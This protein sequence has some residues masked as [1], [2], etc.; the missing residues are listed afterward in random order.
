[1][2]M[3]SFLFCFLLIFPFLVSGQKNDK[4]KST[5]TAPDGIEG[6]TVGME[7][8]EGFF[9]FY[10]D[11]KSDKIMLVIDK[12]G[13]EFLYVHSL[14]AGIGSNDIGLDKNQL[15]GTEVVYFERHGPKVLLFE[16][17][18]RYRAVSDNVKEQQAVADAFARGVIWGFKLITE[19]DGKILVD[20]TD[21]LMQDAHNVAERLKSGNQGTWSVDQSRSAFYLD[22]TRNFPENTEFETILTFTGK[23]AGYNLRSVSPADDNFSVRQHHSFIQLPDDEYEP[24]TF[25]PRAG[26]F[27]TSYFDY[28]T[29]ISEP[30]EKKFINRHRLE[31]KNPGAEVSDPVEPIIYYLDPGT[32]EPIRSALIEGASWWNQAFE[33][34]GYRDAFQVK[35]LPD[36]ADPMDVRYNMINWVHRSTRG[37]SYGSSVTDPR[38]G[39]IIK[40]H[41]LLGSLRVRQDFLIAEGLLAPYTNGSEVPP[42]ME[43]M[44]LARLRQLSAHEVGHTLGLAHS[45]ASSGEGRAS[46]MDY[47]HPMIGLN[48][49]RID[50]SNAYD[51]KIGSWD[52]VAIAYGYQ[53]FPDNADEKEALDEIIQNSLS[54]GLTFISD[55]DARPVGGAH[56]YAHLWDNGESAVEELDHILEV[57]EVALL[58]FGENNIRPGVAY[59]QLESVLVP[60][61]FL[62]RYQTEAAVKLIG[63]LNY[64]YALRGDGQP[65]TEW[66]DPSIQQEALDQL[67]KTLDPEVLTLDEDILKIL[68]PQ[69]IGSGRDR[70]MIRVRTGVTF[71]PLGAAESA[72]AMTASLLFHPARAQRLVE[73]HAR[74]AQQPGLDGVIEQVLQNTVRANAPAG[75]AGETKRAVD[76]VIVNSLIELA[77]NGSS[78]NQVR[79]LT[80]QA[81][82]GLS[83]WSEGKGSA[84]ADVAH[85]AHI[86]R[87]I[88]QFLEDP[89][90]FSVPS[91]LN[92]PDGSPIGVIFGASCEW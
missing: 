7:K 89:D 47:P 13:E 87:K 5:P 79:A 88:D 35:V 2:T 20:A 46:V 15:G 1:M 10:Y 57:R 58:Q 77:K 75:L 12:F 72:A 90:E 14:S 69:P 44:A 22:R 62:H 51:D 81:L 16:K 53:D 56:P 80:L 41:V 42:E 76:E 83:G 70:E 30:L 28:A 54:A 25:D 18:Y 48:N 33:A 34:A 65:V 52:K 86:K 74:N 19:E 85:Y 29:P 40:G 36:D 78:G 38:T 63:G 45:Y 43:E 32:P 60:V 31:K 24:R 9:D 49:G 23:G 61:Y 17:N 3:R 67:L 92:P 37:W 50:L 68:P 82:S 66:V 91:A 26:Y 55:Q 6:K 71:D 4:K 27:G 84:S 59:G 64:R 73:F 11:S 39:E 8:Y 21:F